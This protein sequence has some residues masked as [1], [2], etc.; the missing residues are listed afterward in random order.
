[1][2]R[3]FASASLLLAIVA[4]VAQ[5]HAVSGDDIIDAALEVKRV[6]V[7]VDKI[8]PDGTK[9][10]R[11]GVSPLDT[12]DLDAAISRSL[13]AHGSRV[14]DTIA[15]SKMWRVDS[16]VGEMVHQLAM[17]VAQ[18]ALNLRHNENA[19]SAYTSASGALLRLMQA[20]GKFDALAHQQ[21]RWQ[22]ESSSQDGRSDVHDNGHAFEG[23]QVDPSQFLVAARDV[24]EAADAAAK[25]SHE[26]ESTKGCVRELSRKMPDLA[27]LPKLVDYLDHS[28]SLPSYIPAGNMWA[29]HED[30]LAAQLD[31]FLTMTRCMPYSGEKKQARKMATEALQAYH[32]LTAAIVTLDLLALQET[33]WEERNI[34]KQ[35]TVQEQ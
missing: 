21:T 3:A 9:Y 22:E 25:V 29:A 27:Y 18:C 34:E 13:L 26:S 8:A 4:P 7:L 24:K 12:S 16:V 31:V 1:M 2:L 6:A 17:G 23:G 15:A 19:Q 32:R 11:W 5:F 30:G 14:P 28:P 33:E 35:A 10:C 20:R